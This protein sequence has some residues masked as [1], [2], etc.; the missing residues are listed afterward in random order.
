MLDCEAYGYPAPSV[1]WYSSV[2]DLSD[3]SKYKQ[4]SNGS[5]EIRDV[6]EQDAG[7]YECTASNK[8]GRKTVIRR[9]KVKSECLNS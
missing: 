1:M 5:L 9:L 7:E 6:T 3:S 8:L 4:L 2:R